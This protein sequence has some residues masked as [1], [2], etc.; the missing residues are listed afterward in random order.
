MAET[1]VGKMVQNHERSTMED[2]KAYALARYHSARPDKVLLDTTAAE[3]LVTIP[4]SVARFL[5]QWVH[6]CRHH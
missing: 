4:D 3:Q 2:H 5:F 1:R 6:H